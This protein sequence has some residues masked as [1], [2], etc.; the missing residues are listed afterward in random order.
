MENTKS[1]KERL[2]WDF[3]VA[4]NSLEEET[5]KYKRLQLKREIQRLED[6]LYKH[7]GMIR[8]IHYG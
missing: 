3:W 8:G 4:E 7:Y 1:G 2:K 5:D 6:E